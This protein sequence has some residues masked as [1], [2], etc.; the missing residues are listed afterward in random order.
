V[1]AQKTRIVIQQRVRFASAVVRPT[2]LDAGIWL[3][4][5]AVH[6]RLVRTEDFGR[7]GYVHHF[8]LER[9][10]DIDPALEDLLH[11]AYVEH[12][13]PPKR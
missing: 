4:R 3:R 11:E 6:P 13:T 2:W 5:R 7:L 12:A 1:Y 9:A 10:S 8:R